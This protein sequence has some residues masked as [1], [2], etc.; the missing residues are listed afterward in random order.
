[1]SRT[2]INGSESEESS[3]FAS[4][5]LSLAASRD[6][7]SLHHAITN[8]A[9]H[10]MTEE[11]AR[12][13]LSSQ[14]NISSKNTTGLEAAYDAS[15]DQDSN[16]KDMEL[17]RQISVDAGAANSLWRTDEVEHQYQ[18]RFQLPRS[19][20][21]SAVSAMDKRHGSAPP[22]VLRTK[23]EFEQAY[24]HSKAQSDS[25]DHT[26]CSQ[27]AKDQWGWFEDVHEGETDGDDIDDSM[28]STVGA[29]L[30]QSLPSGMD[31]KGKMLSWK[32]DDPTAVTAPTYVL[33]ESKSSQTLW[34]HT[35]GNRPP[36][37]VEE[38]AFF[39]KLWAQNFERSQVDYQIPP[40]VLVA[41]T[42]FSLN[43]FADGNDFDTNS[44]QETVAHSET[45]T[46][47]SIV[48][49]ADRIGFYGGNSTKLRNVDDFGPYDHHHTTVN[50]KVKEDG[51]DDELTVVVKGDNVFGTTVSKSFSKA[52]EKKGKKVVT[53]SISVA[54]YRVVQSKKHGKYAQFL[55]IYCEGTFRDTVGVWKRYSDFERLSNLVSKGH[56]SCTSAFAGINPLAITEDLHDHEVL[57]NAVTSWKLL[58]KRQRWFRCLDAGYLSLKAF[59]LERFLHDILF[60]STTPDILRD[61]AQQTRD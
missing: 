37:P 19:S 26:N 48:T 21:A 23:T 58:K 32:K 60:E 30:S 50:K 29:L 8:N 45:D 28:H 39:E 33:E 11:D 1:M 40:D 38:R 7:S 54:S 27:P 61:F 52:D 49:Q 35:A 46:V 6:S 44:Y 14:L 5:L 3:R 16:V 9:V 22:T 41:P 20:A 25:S 24:V 43:P 51:T 4:P 42:S 56:E 36:Q 55:V 10:A 53:V 57:P 13:N 15:I 12:W 31:N 47:G 59:L 34:K 17:P 18:N 2:S